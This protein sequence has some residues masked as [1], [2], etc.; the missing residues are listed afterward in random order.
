[1][2]FINIEHHF[3]HLGESTVSLVGYNVCLGL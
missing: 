1:M 2:S 3:L